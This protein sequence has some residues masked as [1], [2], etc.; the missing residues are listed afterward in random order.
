MGVKGLTNHDNYR[1]SRTP[2]SPFTIIMVRI[3]DFMFTKQASRLHEEVFDIIDR[4]ADGSDSLEV[5]HDVFLANRPLQKSL[6]IF[7]NPWLISEFS[8][9]FLAFQGFVMCHSI[10]GG[11]GSGMGSYLLETL[12]D[13]QVSCTVY[14]RSQ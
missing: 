6:F 11:T 10:A 5:F 1:P 14:C 4:E 3:S 8:K 9:V 12:N 7:F 2:L 13:R